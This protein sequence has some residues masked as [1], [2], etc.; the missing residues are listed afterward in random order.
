MCAMRRSISSNRPDPSRQFEVTLTVGGQEFIFPLMSRVLELSSDVHITYYWIDQRLL[1]E[2]NDNPSR[3]LCRRIVDFW[4]LVQSEYNPSGVH[5]PSEGLVLA[6]AFSGLSRRK[7]MHQVFRDA[8]LRR[9]GRNEV[10]RTDLPEELRVRVD[11]AVSQ[12]HS[13]AVRLEFA[14]ILSWEPSSPVELRALNLL[15]D[16]WIDRAVSLYNTNP[17]TGIH[18]FIDEFLITEARARRSSRTAPI[19]RRFLD[20]VLF[21]SKVCFY[22]CYAVLWQML[23]PW[24]C[25]NRNLDL[26]SEQFLRIWHN[27]NPSLRRRQRENDVTSFE[28][29][30]FLG[31]VL[32]LHP[33][34]GI[35]MN[36]P[37]L[38]ALAALYFRNAGP[39]PVIQNN[40]PPPTEYWDL[41]RAI[42]LAGHMY[43]LNDVRSPAT[44]SLDSPNLQFASPPSQTSSPSRNAEIQESLA[45]V[46]WRANLTCRLCHSELEQFRCTEL[47]S[48]NRC[49]MTGY[50]NHCREDS[51][52]EVDISQLT[53]RLSPPE[54]N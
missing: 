27:Q 21:E 24:L 37:E 43:R 54:S 38:C 44:R 7:R 25:Q 11:A 39:E 35:L 19:T 42:L 51:T 4:E 6:R 1:R 14:R 33:L 20:L 32:S 29:D 23:I 3:N 40:V 46:A 50:C 10:Y 12:Q 13:N 53:G 47:D 30:A 48:S 8:S 45:R 49:Q 16:E 2:T 52:R 34:S 17:D 5:S 41:V 15:Y 28:T 26:V 36:T 22:E 9:L 18:Q 31:H